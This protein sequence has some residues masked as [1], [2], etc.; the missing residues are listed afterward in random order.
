MCIWCKIF[1][2]KFGLE[3]LVIALAPAGPITISRLAFGAADRRLQGVRHIIFGPQ[4]ALQTAIC[5]AN[6][7]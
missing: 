7:G 3:I 2:K 4:I 5:A 6:D 1:H